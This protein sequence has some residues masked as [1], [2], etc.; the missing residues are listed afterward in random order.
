MEKE[1]LKKAREK[2]NR[3]TARNQKAKEK[4]ELLKA[5]KENPE[6]REYIEL[7]KFNGDAILTE[8][9]I[10]RSSFPV[11]YVN[12]DSEI[13]S[14]IY[15][16]L[17]N[18]FKEH[19]TT[20]LERYFL[21]SAPDF[22]CDLYADL[23]STEISCI[24]WNRIE[25]FENTFTIL[26]IPQC[27]IAQYGPYVSSKSFWEFRD[28]YCRRLLE[29]PQNEVISALKESYRKPKNN[30]DETVLSLIKAL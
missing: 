21:F 11:G 17:G 22:A 9:Q 4:V 18:Y 2:Y 19:G 27:D 5:L 26:S 28:D 7:S 24:P 30:N 16:Y 15:V 29:S 23:E 10:L 14:G 20:T 6:V 8:Q 25:D 13:T 1:E 3:L 12:K